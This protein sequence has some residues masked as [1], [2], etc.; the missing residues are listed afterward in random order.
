M[1]ELTPHPKA[2]KTT[3]KEH[4][5]HKDALAHDLKLLSTPKSVKE[6]LASPQWREWCAAIDKELGSLIDKGVYEVR[7]IP[8]G[9]KVIPTKLVLRI[10]V[11][12]NLMALSRNTRYAALLLVFFSALAC[13]TIPTNVTLP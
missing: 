10:R 12:L 13:T 5:E 11:K 6:V 4:P 8:A 9:V 7:K 3:I 1:A 2:L